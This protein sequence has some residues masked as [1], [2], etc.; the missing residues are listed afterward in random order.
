MQRNL[1]NLFIHKS[2]DLWKLQRL[3]WY[4]KC[5]NAFILALVLFNTPVILVILALELSRIFASGTNEDEVTRWR[6]CLTII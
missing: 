3:T 1:H 6:F 5:N 2:M 4:N